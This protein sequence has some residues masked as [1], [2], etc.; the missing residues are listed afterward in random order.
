MHRRTWLAALS[1]VVLIALGAGTSLAHDFWIQPSAF[2]AEDEARV[3]A[4]LFVGHGDEIN[5][6]P[7]L[8]HFIVRLEIH[9]PDGVAKVK[10]RNASRPAVRTQLGRAGIYTVVYQS[11]HSYVELE[12]ERFERY[13]LEEGLTG[14]IEERKRRGEEQ[15]PGQESFARYC[16]ALIR[17]GKG[18]KDF[19][20]KLGLPLELTAIDNP[21]AARARGKLRFVLEYRGKAMAN[22]H[23]ELISLDDLDDK[24]SGSTDKRGQVSFKVPH[25]GR[26]MVTST[27]MRRAP[28]SVK[29]DWESFWAN[30]TFEVPGKK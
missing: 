9:G 17:V 25:A 28:S 26:W 30:L 15:K 1:G 27:H 4:R 14:I 2:I 7:Y 3:D 10:S 24:V 6:F 5:E 29:G 18:K 21:F 20:R 13:L 23:V 16:K 8:S 12:P 22:A 19:D 11:H